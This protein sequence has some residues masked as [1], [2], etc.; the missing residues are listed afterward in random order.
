MN[1]T[2]KI[3]GGLFVA[4]VLQGCAMYQPVPEGYTGAVAEVADS[5]RPGDGMKSEIFAITE[6][7]GREI[8]SSFRASGPERSGWRTSLTTRAV[9]RLVLAAP[10]KVKLVGSHIHIDNMRA[11]VGDI[12]GTSFSVSGV[13]DFKPEPGGKYLVKGVLQKGVSSIWIEDRA[14]G[15]PVTQKIVEK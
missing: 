10:Q 5:V 15:L 14:T 4:L 13:V 6:L 12:R 9:S 1:R 7:D 8:H 2:L 11:I 3:T